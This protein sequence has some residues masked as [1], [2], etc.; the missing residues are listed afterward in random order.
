MMSAMTIEPILTA[1][2][3]WMRTDFL[4]APASSVVVLSTFCREL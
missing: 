2:V 4:A 3:L 1:S